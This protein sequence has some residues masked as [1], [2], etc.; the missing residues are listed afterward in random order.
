MKSLLEQ[1]A[2]YNMQGSATLETFH[3]SRITL[4]SKPPVAVIRMKFDVFFSE[5]VLRVGPSNP[6]PSELW[7]TNLREV[8][9]DDKFEEKK[10]LSVR[11]VQFVGHVFSGATTINIKKHGIAA[12]SYQR[13]QAQ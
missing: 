3:G 5:T 12:E 6:N 11:E 8:W 7:R 4:L 10:D 2:A 1:K 9:D 13:N